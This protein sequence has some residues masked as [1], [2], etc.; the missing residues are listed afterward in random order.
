MIFSLEA[1]C[2]LGGKVIEKKKKTV[3]EKRELY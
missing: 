1:V 3:A 2:S